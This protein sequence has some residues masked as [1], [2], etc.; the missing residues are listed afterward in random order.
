M[1]FAG[2]SDDAALTGPDARE[3]A[4]RTTLN[5]SDAVPTMPL[6]DQLLLAKKGNKLEVCHVDQ[7][8]GEV[9]LI[10]VGS[11]KA[12]EKH[13]ANHAGDGVPG[14]GY[15]A[16]CEPD[17]DSDGTPDA[18]DAFPNDPTEIADSDG[19]GV[20]DNADA[21]P[22]DPSET[23]DS[24][25]DGVGDNADAFPNDPTNGGGSC[26]FT[27]DDLPALGE[28][29]IFNL[30]G[31]RTPY[32]NERSVPVGSRFISVNFSNVLGF[33]KVYDAYV[34]D[35][36]SGGWSSIAGTSYLQETGIFSL[37]NTDE[38][39]AEWVCQLITEFGVV[40]AESADVEAE[41]DV[42]E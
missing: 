42:E 20:G 7:D 5:A 38:G 25:G 27:V 40:G 23:A 18:S 28:K 21:F 22:N 12:A 11:D 33:A 6:A 1:V 19:D 15:T 16:T 29:L 3:R 4:P 35:R 14:A 41:E 26:S 37:G 31:E 32:T 24:D 36:T 34:F 9:K 30:S 8:T 2:C 39:A 17:A 13:L 10:S